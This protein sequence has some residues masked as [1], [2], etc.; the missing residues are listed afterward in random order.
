MPQPDTP[1]LRGDLQV[2][3]IV[4]LP[5]SLSPA[6]QQAVAAAFGE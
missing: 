5:R 3:Y 1:S 2:K 4:D 6:Q